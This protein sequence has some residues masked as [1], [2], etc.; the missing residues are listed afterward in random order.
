[1]DSN[2]V[3]AKCIAIPAIALVHAGLSASAEFLVH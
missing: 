1:M 2:R 3:T